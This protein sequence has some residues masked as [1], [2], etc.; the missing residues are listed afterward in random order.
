MHFKGKII[1]KS[2][3]YIGRTRS[4]KDIDEIDIEWAPLQL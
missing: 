1:Q 2:A 3:N 4:S